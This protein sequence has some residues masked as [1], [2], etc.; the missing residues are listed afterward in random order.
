M[1]TL[2]DLPAGLGALWSGPGGAFW[3][4]RGE[5]P[6]EGLSPL[7]GACVYAPPV[8]PLEEPSSPWDLEDP[9]PFRGI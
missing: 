6:L 8:G 1:G 4:Y 3:T 5:A 9:E 2:E 7:V